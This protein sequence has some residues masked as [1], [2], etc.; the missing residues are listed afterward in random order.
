MNKGIEKV[1]VT[2]IFR[3]VEISVDDQKVVLIMN[4]DF[5][6]DLPFVDTLENKPYENNQGSKGLIG[7]LT[8][9]LQA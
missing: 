9:E 4:Q 2:F 3:G 6:L 7:F 8:L 1:S 5:I